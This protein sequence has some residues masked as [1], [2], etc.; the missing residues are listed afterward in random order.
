[1]Q[2]KLTTTVLL[3]GIVLIRC[4][5]A[6]NASIYQ[7]D[8]QIICFVRRAE[9]HAAYR[10]T[11]VTIRMYQTDSLVTLEMFYARPIQ[12]LTPNAQKILGDY[13]AYFFSTDDLITRFNL[14]K[15]GAI[16]P[17][18]PLDSIVPLESEDCYREQLRFDG[19]ILYGDSGR[20]VPC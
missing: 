5:S 2:G 18:R 14:G 1:M 11:V 6:P 19:M 4:E 20:V 12:G 10:S 16:T 3:I 7:L 8:K 17:S 13:T 9:F 15:S